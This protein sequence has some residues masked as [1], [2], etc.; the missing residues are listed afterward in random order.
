MNIYTDDKGRDQRICCLLQS[1]SEVGTLKMRLNAWNQQMRV[2]QF[3]GA[4]TAARFFLSMTFWACSSARIGK[5]GASFVLSARKKSMH[6]SPARNQAVHTC[7]LPLYGLSHCRSVEKNHQTFSFK[8][9]AFRRR[10][11]RSGARRERRRASR[12][13]S[14]RCS[15]SS[16]PSSTPRS[17]ASGSR[18]APREREPP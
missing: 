11:R 13:A 5:A 7:P 2:V 18:H 10:R 15:R 16:R 3:Q 14:R 6:D 8:H 17:S 12:T 4:P 1:T 9:R